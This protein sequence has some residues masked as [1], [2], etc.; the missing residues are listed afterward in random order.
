MSLQSLLTKLITFATLLVW[1]L[2]PKFIPQLL[3]FQDSVYLCWNY[4]I[5]RRATHREQ[6]KKQKIILVANGWCYGEC[7]QRAEE[8][9]P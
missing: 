9:V 5:Q 2:L 6:I 8:I 4:T 1:E 3:L 7:S